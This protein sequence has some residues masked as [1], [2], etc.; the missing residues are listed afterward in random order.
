MAS[1]ID[2][3]EQ[4]AQ[5]HVAAGAYP[6]IEWLVQVDGHEW[7]RGAAGQA[8]P[9]SNVPLPGKPIYRLYSMTKPVISAIALML[10]EEGRL[11]LYDPVAA[12]LPAFGRMEIIDAD[13]TLHPAGRVMLV[14]HLLTHRSGLTYGFLQSCPAA[15][16]YRETRLGSSHEPL[17][18]MVDTIASLPLAF[19]PGSQWRYSVATD[20]MARIIEV[21][22]GKPLQQVVDERVI[23]PLGLADTGFMVKPEAR[24]RLVPMFGKADLDALMVFDEGPQQLT[25]ADVSSHYPVD[26][27][28]FARGGYGLY[29]TID[30]YAAICDLLA[31]GTDR[32]G[33]IL[34]SRHMVK[35]M[36][37]NRI[38]ESQMPLAIG[39]VPLPGYGFSLAG[40]VM[41]DL[42]RSVSMTGLGEFGWSGAAGTF[43]W[44]DPAE[45]M[46]GVVMTQYLGSKL[47]LADDM[48][49][50]AYQ[51]LE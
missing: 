48:R 14:E 26:D 33:D 44:I 17:E 4:V 21:I 51:A 18:T 24:Q 5:R 27:P 35:F 45:N 47:P 1:R 30:D 25:P 49:T 7:L 12:F 28:G 39:P 10:V 3:I 43:F 29:S 20:V 36:W 31:T 32:N 22:E 37:T 38:P 40:R 13:G 11:H 6:S 50:A 16:R 41:S 46:T 42:S 8:D 19:E 9:L 23:R 34:L 15:A 2:R